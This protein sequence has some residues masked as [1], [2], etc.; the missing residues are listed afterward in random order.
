MPAVNASDACRGRWLD[1]LTHF[2]VSPKFLSDNHGPCPICGGKDRF[3]FDNK[4]GRGT[5]ICNHCGSGDGFSLLMK[6]NG[7]DFKT[8]TGHVL[9]YAMTV[10]PAAVR[11]AA[12]D[13]RLAR[14]AINMWSASVPV[15]SGDP[16]GLYLKSR[17]LTA[18]SDQIR[19]LDKCRWQDRNKD[20]RWM[21]AMIS[22]VSNPD[23]SLATLHRTYLTMD[24]KKAPIDEP[25]KLF[26]GRISREAA[27]RLSPHSGRLGV[28]EG[29]ET[30]MAA[31]SLFGV[32]TWSLINSS[33]MLGFNVPTDVSELIVFAD[34][35]LNYAGQM[36]AYNLAYRTRISSH[37]AVTVKV[38]IPPRP[39][40]D[41]NDEVKK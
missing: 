2:G 20:V 21:P 22:R 36:S 40:T 17:G 4:D 16:V 1:I 18:M 27:I 24:G 6:L 34:N 41:W 3:R 30:A 39:G 35:D 31:E 15:T 29:I 26:P 9:P 8:A 19:Y 11:A 7:W 10:R 33:R 25:R 28:A 14:M 38:V 32:P 37:G 5:W 13:D 23:G 12:A